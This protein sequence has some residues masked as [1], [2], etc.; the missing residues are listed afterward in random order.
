M[1]VITTLG[2]VLFMA[3]GA[4]GQEE[5]GPPAEADGGGSDVG[6]FH[7]FSNFQTHAQAHVASLVGY[8]SSFREEN[9]LA[10]AL[11]EINGPPANSRNIAGVY[12]RGEAAKFIYGVIG[13]GGGERGTLPDPPPGEVGAYY[14][15]DPPEDRWQG[16]VTAANRFQAVDGTAYAKAT[17]IPTGEADAAFTRLDLPEYFAAESVSARS[18]TNP[19]EFGV[20][21]EA[22]SVL[23]GFVAGPLRIETLSSH[24]YAYMAR[25]AEDP[26]G[27]ATTII[28]GATVNDIP[29]QI[30]D[31]G[32][33]AGENTSPGAQ[34]QINAAMKGA[35]FTEVRLTPASAAAAD[36]KASVSTST[37]FL[38]FVHY[39]EKFGA[40]NPQGFSGGGF[41]VGGAEASV[42]AKRCEPDCPGGSSSGSGGIPDLE[43]VGDPVP[44]D[45]GDRGPEARPD[46]TTYDPSP[47]PAGSPSASSS[48]LPDFGA[49][50]P[51]FDAPL[52][53]E[54][55]SS[56][57]SST[58]AFT[59][60]APEGLDGGS[61]GY[62][63]SA[64]APE[65]ED[66]SS[67][68]ASSGS[69][70]QSTVSP[71]MLPVLALD[72]KSS[73]W[74]RDLYLAIATGMMVIVIAQRVVKA[75]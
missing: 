18:H 8:L 53:F 75:R 62:E 15:T 33:I 5:L 36:D 19:T 26:V 17:E 71:E 48:P 22:V 41:T 7:G 23:R 24:A 66:D 59:P 64:A 57:S 73:D 1:G 11:S 63:E 30:T 74:M 68:G 58:Y 40:S 56:G 12:Q 46:L 20:E 35:G 51:G 34:E 65:P 21:A 25:S 42:A 55:F 14:P 10:G 49:G 6:G 31:K 70:E 60:S 44:N 47:A 2:S 39:D 38:S 4:R 54:S 28:E 50:A 67:T 72:A 27:R 37:G 3:P 13:G 61:G 32:V 9:R 52:P 16:P 29:V 43:G 69:S 45:E